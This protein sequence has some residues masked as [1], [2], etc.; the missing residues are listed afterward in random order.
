MLKIGVIGLGDIAKKAYLPILSS[1]GEIELHLYTRNKAT[2]TAIGAQYRLL[3]LHETLESLFESGIKGAF[4]HAATEAHEELVQKLLER[5]IH[6]YVDKPITYDYASTDRL[7]ELAERQGL[8]LMV[9]FNRR[10]APAYQ[11]LKE[12]REPNMIIMQKNR[13]QLPGDIRTFVFDDFIHVIDTL[14]YLFPYPIEEMRVHGRKKDDLLYHVVVQFIGG[15][16]TAIGIMNR[17]SGTVEEK[18]EVM[19]STE[20]RTAYNLAELAT[21]QGK[22]ETRAGF[23]DWDTTLHKRG[24][25]QIIGRFI[26]SLQSDSSVA[27]SANEILRTHKICEEVVEILSK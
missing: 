4:V 18:V 21:Q 17:D 8:Q 20:K 6:V 25:E 9:G 26:H 24:F 13:M 23:N 3:H 11:K 2:L 5:Q 16:A 19:T 14:L 1:M 22:L 15:G 27:L 10:F 7:V 12:L